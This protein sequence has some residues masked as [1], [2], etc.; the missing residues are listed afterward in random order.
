MKTRISVGAL[1]LAAFVALGGWWYWTR[2]PEYSLD[3]AAKA[4]QTHDWDLFTRH[5]DVD[6]VVTSLVDAAVVAVSTQ[7]GTAKN[8]WEAAGRNLGQ[9]LAFM[10]K[11]RIA[12]EFR[13]GIRKAVEETDS[14]DR[15]IKL[16]SREGVDRDGKVA[17]AHLVFSGPNGPLFVALN[18][19]DKG[20]HW[21]VSNIANA[22]AVMGQIK[23]TDVG[24]RP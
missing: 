3:Q 14:K 16:L 5:V 17:Q 2:T 19:R 20:D 13:N 1:V 9:G 7:Q 10:M 21:Q 24:D 18:M 8:E 15:K 6:G 4:I 11:P 22:L 12:E 23:G